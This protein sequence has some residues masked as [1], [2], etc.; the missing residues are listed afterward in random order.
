LPEDFRRAISRQGFRFAKPLA[1]GHRPGVEHFDNLR[2]ASRTNA[3]EDD[4]AGH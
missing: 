4:D 3:E 1:L 2:L